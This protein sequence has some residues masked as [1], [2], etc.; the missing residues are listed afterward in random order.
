M[1][2]PQYQLT[3]REQTTDTRL[4]DS[5]MESGLVQEH[6]PYVRRKLKY[7]KLE[8]MRVG[9]ETEAM[10]KQRNLKIIDLR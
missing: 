9:S 4:S 2:P 10:G 1:P 3:A 6:L 5:V 8:V 7:H